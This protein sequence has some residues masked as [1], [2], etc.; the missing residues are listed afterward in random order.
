ML[1][2]AALYAMFPS[3]DFRP[4]FVF[5]DKCKSTQKDYTHKHHICPRKQF[6]EFV[7]CI[8]NLILLSPE[9]HALAHK[10]LEQCE[11]TLKSPPTL[12]IESQTAEV[13]AKAGRANSVENKVKAGT[14]SGYKHL[15]RKTGIFAPNFDKRLPGH[16]GGH[17]A[18]AVLSQNGKGLYS[19]EVRDKGVLAAVAAHKE[20]GT[21]FYSKEMQQRG[22][23]VRWH[24]N[25]GVM[26]S[27]CSLCAVTA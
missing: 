27:A 16:I 7:D 14:V 23:H 4:Y 22:L 26:S 17:N 25:R 10:L 5:L 2:Q 3:D 18:Q 1:A 12:W 24:V 15:E 21:G 13:Q 19:R 11:A 20:R 6:P 8:W 9:E